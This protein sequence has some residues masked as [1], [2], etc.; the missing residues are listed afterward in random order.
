MPPMP[1]TFFIFVVLLFWLVIAALNAKPKQNDVAVIRVIKVALFII[2]V[3][4]IFVRCQVLV[5][6]LL[7]SGLRWPE[8]RRHKILLD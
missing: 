4:Y 7:L 6:L 3:Q 5:S 1:V 8:L 2:T